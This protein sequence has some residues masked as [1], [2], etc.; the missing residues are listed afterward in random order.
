LKQALSLNFNVDG[1]VFNVVIEVDIV[2]AGL[3]VIQNR[4]ARPTGTIHPLLLVP[5]FFFLPP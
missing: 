4:A 1:A 5:V 3:G 2:G